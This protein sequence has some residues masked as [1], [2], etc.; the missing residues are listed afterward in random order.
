MTKEASMRLDGSKD[1]RLH[2][3]DAETKVPRKRPVES[4]EQ[5]SLWRAVLVYIGYVLVFLFGYLDEFV[6]KIG[7][8]K[9]AGLH[10]PELEVS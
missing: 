2:P 1:M 5:P 6:R 3:T 10:D 7:L 8:K 9:M 4:F